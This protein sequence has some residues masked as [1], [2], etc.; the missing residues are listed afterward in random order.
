MFALISFPEQRV[1]G[2]GRGV[3]LTDADRPTA[4]AMSA[5]GILRKAKGDIDKDVR[6][7]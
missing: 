5:S 3:G 6:F 2:E 1:R 4:P 7:M